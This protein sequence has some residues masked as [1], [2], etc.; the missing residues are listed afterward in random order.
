MKKISLRQQLINTILVRNDDEDNES[1]R[2]FLEQ[3]SLPELQ[4]LA[5]ND[6]EEEINDDEL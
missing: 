2:A 1:E 5:G 3:L 4:A 6:P